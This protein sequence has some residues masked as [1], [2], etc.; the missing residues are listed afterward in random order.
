MPVAAAPSLVSQPMR[1]C[2]WAA[3]NYPAR[4]YS[5]VL[6]AFALA[7]PVA[8]PVRRAL[9]YKDHSPVPTTWPIPNRKREAVPTEFDDPQ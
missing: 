3:R 1:Y 5:V 9:G 6:G 4:F 8:I 2:R 7:V